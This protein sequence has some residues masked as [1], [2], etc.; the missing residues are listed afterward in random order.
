MLRRTVLTGGLLLLAGCG[1]NPKDQNSGS[2]PGSGSESG[3]GS[4]AG[5]G[6]TKSAAADAATK[7][8]NCG[9]PL[10]FD[11]VPTRVVSTYPAMTEVMIALGKQNLLAGQINTNLSPPDPHYAQEFAKVKVLA[12]GEP[13]VEVLLSA[14]PDLILADGPYHFDGKRLPTIDDLAKRGIPVYINPQFC[15]GKKLQG[16]VDQAYGELADLGKIFD[17]EGPA[18]TLTDSAEATLADVARRIS[19]QPTRPAAIVTLYEKSLY[20][21]AGGLYTDVLR[22]AGGQNVTAQNELPAGEYYGQVSPE[23]VARKNPEAIVYTYLD[24]EGRRTSDDQL[25]VMFKN[26]KAVKES[27]LIGVPESIFSG[28]LRSFD[29]VATL[30][31][32]LHPDAF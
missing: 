3:P 32:A 7:L 15:E 30:A 11:A 16:K 14:R 18:Q 20:A 28:S 13:S 21:D 12:E 23:S 24:E 31:K 26:T 19:D 6:S 22:L 27:R 25:R 8:D 1:G 2:E 29:G 5:S 9:R 10:T 17:A 4:G